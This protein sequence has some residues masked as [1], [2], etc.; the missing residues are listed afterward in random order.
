[1][2]IVQDKI[3][4]IFYSKVQTGQPDINLTPYSVRMV[5]PS[6][7]ITGDECFARFEP[8]DLGAKLPSPP[9]N[10]QDKTGGYYCIYTVQHL[11]N[12]LNPV[13]REAFNS[14]VEKGYPEKVGHFLKCHPGYYPYIDTSLKYKRENKQLFN[15]RN[16][17]QSYRMIVDYYDYERSPR[18]KC[19][20][21][22]TIY[23]VLVFI[24][25]DMQSI[26]KAPFIT[27][28]DP[29]YPESGCNYLME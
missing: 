19:T 7:G 21:D 6:L 26:L 13:F 22:E 18:E 15:S 11:L 20:L 10:Y 29:K 2:S 17:T 12:I 16:P 9:L 8:Q 25:E 27:L 24:N 28:N 4:S 3:K 5:C 1:M 23:P 14:L